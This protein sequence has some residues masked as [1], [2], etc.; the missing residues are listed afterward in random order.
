MK[1]SAVEGESPRWRHR[2]CNADRMRDFLNPGFSWC[3]HAADIG[4]VGRIVHLQE[5]EPYP[6]LASSAS[7]A[8]HMMQSACLKF[9]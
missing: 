6:W 9:F 5:V 3:S 7:F 1:A 4:S 8:A 2:F